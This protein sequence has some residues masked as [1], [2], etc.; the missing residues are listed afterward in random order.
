MWYNKRRRQHKPRRYGQIHGQKTDLRLLCA[1]NHCHSRCAELDH[2]D[3]WAGR[4][5]LCLNRAK[6]AETVFTERRRRHVDV[7]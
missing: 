4:N 2:I 7:L 6:C 1:S 5:N 3:T